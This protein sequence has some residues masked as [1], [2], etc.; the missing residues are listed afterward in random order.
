M[1]F[2]LKPADINFVRLRFDFAVSDYPSVCVCSTSFSVEH[3]MLCKHGEFV[4]HRKLQS[5][6]CHN[7]VVE[8][9]LQSITGKV[10]NGGSN[11]APD[12][13]LNVYAKGFTISSDAKSF[14]SL[15]THEAGTYLRFL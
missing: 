7:L 1:H 2:E 4:D 13:C 3:A 6:V 12:A 5:M 9:N 15:V 11:R 10:L 14:I 8:S